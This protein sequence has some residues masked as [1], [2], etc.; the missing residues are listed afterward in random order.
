MAKR[1]NKMRKFKK[2]IGKKLLTDR[3]SR[4]IKHHLA[5]HLRVYGY[6]H[7]ETDLEKRFNVSADKGREMLK[8]RVARFIGEEMMKNGDIEISERSSG[9]QG[10][11]VIEFSVNVYKK[12]PKK[13]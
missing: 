12:T 2:Q 5:R 8:I 3:D 1:T 7:S 11:T 9:P 6:V 10:V 4:V 13:K